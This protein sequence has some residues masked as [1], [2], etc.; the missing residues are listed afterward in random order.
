MALEFLTMNKKKII[1]IFGLIL[2]VGFSMA[3]AQIELAPYYNYSFVE[4]VSVSP[5]GDTG[6][7]VSL[8]NDIGTI[9]RPF[10]N[11]SFIGYYSLK[12]QGPGLKKQEGREFSERYLDH[13]FVGR[14]HWYLDD[15]TVIKSQLDLLMEARRSG[16]NENWDNG[17]YN[18]N[19]YGG[20]SSLNKTIR[21]I[22]STITFGYHFIT[23]P[24][25][26][27]MLSEIRYGADPS[28]SEGKQN[29]HVINTTA[30]GEYGPYTGKVGLTAQ[31][32]TNQKVAVDTVQDDGSFY[33]DKSQRDLSALMEISREQVLSK[34]CITI[35]EISFTY[36]NS[37]QNY[38]HFMTATSTS[39]V[40]YH[41]DF[42]D[43]TDLSV[44]SPFTLQ[45]SKKW[46]FILDPE[47]SYKY[48][49]HRKPRDKSGV[50]ISGKKQQRLLGM[51]TLGF[52]NQIG[53]SSSSMIFF[54]YH[55][56]SSN[57]KFEKYVPYNYDGFSVGF[58]FGMEY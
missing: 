15:D 6:F 16:T 3:S 44:S 45:L 37:N 9:V 13:L 40:S 7:L 28:A 34:R 48:H 52:K 32:Y 50:F 11:H 1:G 23:F 24:N 51:F 53:E 49:I 43:Y 33:S 14:H 39:P 22:D 36:K 17:L 26:T 5:E 58:K 30:K 46:S 19:R 56:Q 20:N 4:G 21:G 42:F 41:Q 38:Q 12:Y 10:D 35:P 25:Y 47:L 18:Y 29:H 2:V 54:T 55:N 27:D 57:M 31:L 8:S